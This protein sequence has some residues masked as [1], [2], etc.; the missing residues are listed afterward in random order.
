MVNVVSNQYKLTLSGTVSV[1]QYKLEIV[2]ME[3]WDAHLVQKIINFKRSALDKALGLYVCSGASI[4]VLSGLEEDVVFDVSLQGAK[5][6]IFIDKSTLS[7][8][9]LNGKF[10]NQDNSVS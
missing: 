5:Y 4:Y 9:Q 8:V 2:G 6:T 3:M 1:F 7:M 10:D